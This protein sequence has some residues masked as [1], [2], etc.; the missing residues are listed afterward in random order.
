[1]GVVGKPTG[2]AGGLRMAERR[3]GS[4]GTPR[5][6]VWEL[7]EVVVMPFTAVEET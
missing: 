2:F 1:M 6:S 5:S 3:E 7:G 4:R